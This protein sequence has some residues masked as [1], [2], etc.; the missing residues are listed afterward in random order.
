MKMSELVQEAQAELNADQRT[1]AKEVI[2][3]RLVEV[4]QTKRALAAMEEQLTELLSKEVEDV[5]AV[6]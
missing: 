4:Q 2:K 5:V 6:E 1:A 3:D